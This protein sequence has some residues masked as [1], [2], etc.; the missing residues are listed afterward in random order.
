MQTTHKGMEVFMKLSCFLEKKLYYSFL[1]YFHFRRIIYTFGL[2]KFMQELFKSQVGRLR[3][4]AFMEGCSLLI[5]LFIAMPIKYLLDV[6][7]ATQAIGLIHGI[8]FI[9]FVLAT[10]AVSVLHR[11]NISRIFIVMISSMLPFGT[12]YIDRKILS[13]LPVKG[14]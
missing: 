11:W 2:L 3:I 4:I 14:R 7:E 13:K 12:F 1:I 8:L 9:L 6:P 5:L 10:L